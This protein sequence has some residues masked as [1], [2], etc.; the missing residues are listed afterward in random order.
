MKPKQATKIAPAPA[1]VK[2]AP[3]VPKKIRSIG[4]TPKLP[5]GLQVREVRF[6]HALNIFGASKTHIRPTDRC[7]MVLDGAQLWIERTTTSGARVI[8]E[9]CSTPITNIQVFPFDKEISE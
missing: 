8:R 7:V 4:T 3:P 1:A 9:I 6:F 5:D 2:P